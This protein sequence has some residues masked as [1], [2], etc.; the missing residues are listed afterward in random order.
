[1]TGL[2]GGHSKLAF[3]G[4]YANKVPL[5]AM[6]CITLQRYGFSGSRGTATGKIYPGV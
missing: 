3:S 5:F 1:M 2:K 6:I 4:K